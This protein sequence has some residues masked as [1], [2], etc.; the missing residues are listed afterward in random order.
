MSEVI[1]YYASCFSAIAIPVQLF[2]RTAGSSLIQN[3]CDAIPNPCDL[4]S[5]VRDLAAVPDQKRR[6]GD[7]N[8]RLRVSGLL[9][10]S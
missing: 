4:K 6:T 7:R 2:L 3:V 5:Q 8:R 9:R 10:Q 1:T